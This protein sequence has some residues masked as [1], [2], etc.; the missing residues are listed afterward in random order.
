MYVGRMFT[1][2]SWCAIITI[3]EIPCTG[4]D[5]TRSRSGSSTRSSLSHHPAAAANRPMINS[6]VSTC[7][8]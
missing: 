2:T 6:E 3:A 4:L 1:L 8:Q 5:T 7:T